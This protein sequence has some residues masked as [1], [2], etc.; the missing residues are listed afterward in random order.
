MGETSG[1]SAWH[2]SIA[3][4]GVAILLGKFGVSQSRCVAMMIGWV[5]G[6]WVTTWWN[7][8]R[9]TGGL[10]ADTKPQPPTPDSETGPA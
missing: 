7:G 3:G 10:Q 2:M 9:A 8:R 1:K 4:L 6:V 5:V